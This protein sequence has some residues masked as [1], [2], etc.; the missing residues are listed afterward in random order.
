M[1]EFIKLKCPSC[2]ADLRI[3]SSLNVCYCQ[4]CGTRILIDGQSDTVINAKK[5]IE[6]QKE[7]HRAEKEKR[8]FET[9][10]SN[11]TFK[12]LIIVCSVIFFLSVI[13][14]MY[15]LNSEKKEIR[16]LDNL[17]SEILVDIQNEDYDMALLKANRL[18]A[19]DNQ[20]K[21]TRKEWDETRENLIE[22]INAKKNNES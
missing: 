6:M 7:K 16:D 20:T 1:I 17:Y 13:G 21:E 2:D 3:D 10:E 4:Y 19:S 9:N 8:E 22:E 15:F 14:Y 5:E 11:K 18:R 12:Q